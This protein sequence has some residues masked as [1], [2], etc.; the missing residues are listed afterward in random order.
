MA[1]LLN[2]VQSS[3]K[4]FFFQFGGQGSPYLKEVTKLY[5]D[6]PLL[7]EYFETVFRCFGKQESRFTKSDRRFEFGYDLKSWMENPD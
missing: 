3:G 7:K 4:K 5:K 6:E 2:E 1:K